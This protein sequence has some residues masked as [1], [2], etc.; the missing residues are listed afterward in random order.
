MPASLLPTALL[1]LLCVALVTVGAEEP[2]R[3]FT[4]AWRCYTGVGDDGHSNQFT[5]VAYELRGGFIREYEPEPQAKGAFR[6]IPLAQGTRVTADVIALVDGKELWRALYYSGGPD[7]PRRGPEAAV[8]LLAI[9]EGHLRP[10][11]VLFPDE[12]ESLTSYIAS[13]RKLPFSLT[14]RTDMSGTGVFYSIYSFSFSSGVPRFLGRTDGGR[15]N[16]PKTYK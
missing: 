15:H 13:S 10:F 1:V 6:W 4:P 9:T 14:A 7:T 5:D 2:L 16:D 12:T 11:C 8:F 3:S